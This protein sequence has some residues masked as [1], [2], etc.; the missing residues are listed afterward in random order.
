MEDRMAEITEQVRTSTD[1]DR[2]TTVWLDRP[3]KPVNTIAPRMQ[4]EMNAVLETIERDRPAGVIFAS[5]KARSFAAGADLFEIQ[6]M[7]RDQVVQY[8]AYGQAIFDRIAALKMPTAAAINGDCLGGGYELALACT[9]RVAVNDGSINIGLP[10]TKLGILPGWGGTVR[11]PRLIGLPAALP[12]MLA[13]KTMP[14]SKARKA[15]LVDET[16]RPEALMSAAKRLVLSG[17]AR[18]RPATMARAAAAV[19]WAR[20]TIFKRAKEK[21][22]EATHGNYPAPINL[23]EVVRTGY[24]CGP[25]AG[26]EA[27]RRALVEL[28]DTSACRNLMRLFFLRQGAKKAIGEQLH[29]KPAEVKYAAVVG[30]GT[31]GAGIAYCFAR[32]G[33]R[34]RL[35]EVN[36][37]ALSAGL[38]RVRKMLDDDMKSGRLGALEA[39]HAMNRVAPSVDWSGIS[40]ADFVV[41]AVVEEMKLK[42]EVFT[43]LDRM[44]RADAVL[45]SNTSSLSI[46]EM[47]RATRRPERIVGMHFFNPVPRMPLVEI[48]RGAASHDQALATAAGLAIRIGKTPVLVADAPGFLVNRVLIPYLAE[49]LVAASE[50]TTIPEIDEAMKRW[51]MP[52]G[53][54]ELLDEIGLDVGAH[55]LGSLS[56]QLGERVPA[57]TPA[58]AEALQNRWLGKKT[59]RG[60]YVYGDDARAK[61]KPVLNEELARKVYSGDRSAAADKPALDAEVQRE[62][63]QWRLV[64]PMVNEAARL[65]EEH[66]VGSTDAVDLATVLGTGFAPFRGGLAQFADRVGMESIAS[67]LDELTTRHGPRFAPAPLI[68]RLAQA[69]RPLTEFASLDASSDVVIP[70]IIAEHAGVTK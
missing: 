5:P 61:T 29:A 6:K 26:L 41:E 67:R 3:G 2:V 24:E 7:S 16:V 28:T 50:G 32:A 39:R 10:E 44:T 34:V 43:R 59:R 19:P 48:V 27:E 69:R 46:G 63:I 15:G 62:A 21:T 12:L 64:L 42:H 9:Y 40:L 36:A 20:S 18:R 14:P 58:I 60:F 68:L 53:P 25:E 13:G 31:M 38:G 52:M 47:A 17:G 35:L 30:A 11:L 37:E 65:L 51:G 1:A 49:A 70:S 8:L 54:F 56:G 23:I 22:L 57:P 55:V 66:V 45:A 4:R 33:I